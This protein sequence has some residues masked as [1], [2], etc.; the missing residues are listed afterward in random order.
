[1]NIES[2]AIR[3]SFQLTER[4]RSHE[5]TL[6]HALE[7]DAIQL[8]EQQTRQFFSKVENERQL[9][10]KE[11][12]LWTYGG[13]PTALDA[14]M[15]VFIA[16]LMDVKRLDLVPPHMAK[17]VKDFRSTTEWHNVMQGRPTL[18]DSS[19]VYAK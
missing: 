12:S 15:A 16:R 17:L 8:A 10:A 3:H 19:V 11:G 13:N 18:Y 14:H 1:M 6:V 2:L 9:Y 7:P 4:L 5:K